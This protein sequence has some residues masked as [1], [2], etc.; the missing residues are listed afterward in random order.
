MG[1]DLPVTVKDAIALR[2]V[3]IDPFRAAY[4]P[5]QVTLLTETSANRRLI[6]AKSDQN[7]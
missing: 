7:F 6:L 3:L 4:T 1:A 5:D 2:D